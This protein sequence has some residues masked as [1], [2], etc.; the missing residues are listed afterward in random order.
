MGP[1]FHCSSD[2]T[3]RRVLTQCRFRNS[4]LVLVA[5][6]IKKKHN[7]APSIWIIP[8]PPPDFSEKKQTMC[9]QI[10]VQLIS[11]KI[12]WLLF[13]TLPSETK[14]PLEFEISSQQSLDSLD[15]FPKTGAL[16]KWGSASA[17]PPGQECGQFARNFYMDLE[18]KIGVYTPK[19][20]GENNGK[21][22]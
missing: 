13:S 3:F 11:L 1:L 12:R 16:F 8:Y 22:Y 6:L 19:M 18:P 14:N 20:D 9:Q 4:G 5:F 21:P 2:P 15:S 17:P 7:I 10:S